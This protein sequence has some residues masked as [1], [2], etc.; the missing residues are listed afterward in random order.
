[1]IR[2]LAFLA[3]ALLLAAC[4]QKGPL[5]LPEPPPAAAFAFP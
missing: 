3:L 4:G 2:A 5:K 1:M